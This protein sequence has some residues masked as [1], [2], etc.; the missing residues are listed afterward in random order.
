M[1]RALFHF[2]QLSLLISFLFSPVVVLAW[3]NICYSP[4]QL[5][6]LMSK[7]KESRTS[8]GN[9]RKKIRN[10]NRNI[11]QIERELD[12]QEG[13]LA[14]S[15][16]KELLQAKPSQVSGQIRDYIESQK[17][18]WDCD[19][20]GQSFFFQSYL[21]LDILGHLLIPP[22]FGETGYSGETLGKGPIS[23]NEPS[24]AGETKTMEDVSTKCTKSGGV[25]NS[26]PT[27]FGCYCDPAKGLKLQDDKCTKCPYN[28]VVVGN[29]CVC[30]SG[31][32]ELE[33]GRCKNITVTQTPV[34]TQAQMNCEEGTGEFR[35]GK[36]YCGSLEVIM[37][38]G[39]TCQ[40]KCNAKN[41]VWASGQCT[42]CAS[43]KEV[44]NNKCVCPQ[45]TG[46]TREGVCR[47]IPESR[48]SEPPI[49]PSSVT[50][51]PLQPCEQ[52]P[53][54]VNCKR[55]QCIN[56]NKAWHEAEQKCCD[57]GQIVENGQCK[58]QSTKPP[59]PEWKKHEAFGNKGK[60]KSSFCDDYASDQKQCKKA[61]KRMKQL[62][63][64]IS[65]LEDQRD[66]W[67]D[68]LHELQMSSITQSAKET[69][70]S[71][72]CIDCLKRTMNASQ[73]ST[74]QTVGNVLK[75]LTGVGISAMGYNMGQRAQYDLNMLRMQQGYDAQNDYYPLH[76][77]S[78]GVPYIAHG[79]YGL[80]RTN[81][82]LGGW[83][84]SPTL[85]PYGY[86]QNYQHGQGFNML[87]H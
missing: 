51:D 78:A 2:F 1:F 24:T 64:Q 81:T 45:G 46:E 18:G 5:A 65:Q 39:E 3:N 62:A 68:Q 54:S 72:I 23:G 59:C 47:V 58:N 37:G 44:E 16:S 13:F 22:A 61:L 67:E 76:G 11:R 43:S 79:L 55:E 25:W 87:Y 56:Q 12:K 83:S 80:T 29:Q 70:A 57:T 14:D 75:M 20:G 86:A 7:P 49:I 32:K 74:G 6:A 33:G 4:I 60:V 35:N 38:D 10:V 27:N 84:C 34:R 15:L 63:D 71:G 42:S 85:S 66:E 82:P 50:T 52:N 19:E 17:G 8:I 73:P 40:K 9:V 36:C 26:H 30:P 28:Q 31:M 77:A 69:E 48:H 53:R 41:K 21:F